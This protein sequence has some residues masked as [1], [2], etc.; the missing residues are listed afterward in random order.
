MRNVLSILTVSTLTLFAA[1]CG[2]DNAPTTPAPNASIKGSNLATALISNFSSSLLAASVGSP[3]SIKMKF[4]GLALSQNEDCS[5]PE[6]VFDIRTAPQTYDLVAGPTLFSGSLAA[7]TYKCVVMRISDNIKFKVDAAAVAAWPVSCPNTTTEY[8]HDIYR[9]DNGGSVWKDVEGATITATGSIG[10]PGEDIV[11][12]FAST[13]PT[14]IPAG[15]AHVDQTLSLSGAFTVP[16][17]TTFFADFNNGINEN[18]GHCVLE[19]GGFGV[20]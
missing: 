4:Y 19:D 5:D 13:S 16:G 6:V 12:V 8:T 11:E 3:T 18:T 10:T 7:G 9:T 20:R 1:G 15:T 14:S 2:K 17:S